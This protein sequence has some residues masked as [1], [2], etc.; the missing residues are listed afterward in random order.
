[1]SKRKRSRSVSPIQAKQNGRAT[2][3]AVRRVGIIVP[4]FILVGAV[5]ALG[6]FM[7]SASPK[8]SKG[9][10][11]TTPPQPASTPDYSAAKPAK[12][13]IHAN[14]KLVAISEPV[15]AP[16]DLAVWRLSTGTW[17]ILDQDGSNTTE[18]FGLSNDLPA[19]GDYDGDGKTD[20]CV[21]RPSEAKWY[22]LASGNNNTL[23]VIP[24]GASGDKPVP[25]DYNGDGKTELALYRESNQTWYLHDTVQGY[26]GS[27]QYGSPGD[28]P[29][30]SD[31]DGD[32]KADLAIWRA[33]IGTWFV[34]RSSDLGSTVQLWGA[35]GDKPVPGDYDG[36]G[37]TD[38]A[39]WQSDN[40]WNIRKSSTGSAMS[41]V[42]WGYQASDKEVQGDYDADGKTDIACWRPLTGTWY[43]SE[44]TRGSRTQTWGMNG[45]IPVPAPYRR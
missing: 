29:V 42:T 45:D 4:L 38:F 12:E 20:F 10:G 36:D 19:P 40:V 13:Y 23:A 35:S 21:F 24:F 44:S 22:M 17:W 25:A 31:Y 28:T 1:M 9:F 32:G 26:M 14:G 30:P 33:G 11:S 2:K 5:V 7:N 27:A 37:K 18:A 15:N 8:L 41:P 6:A 43:I 34:L 39:V 16:I 3:Q